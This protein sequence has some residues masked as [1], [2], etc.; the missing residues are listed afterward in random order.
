MQS[1][2]EE[3]RARILQTAYRLFAQ[4]GYDATGV[5]QICSEAGVS[6][7]A[8]YHH[9]PGKHTVFMCLL[10]DWLST[11]NI[12]MNQLTS[13]ATT[14]PQTLIR[15][16][17]ALNHIFRDARGHFPMFLEFWTQSSRDPQV[18]QATVAPYRRYQ[19]YFA[20]LLQQG[21]EEGSIRDEDVDETASVIIAMVLGVIL[22]GLLEPDSANGDRTAQKGME[23]IMQAIARRST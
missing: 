19:S 18:W 20:S 5:S 23:L 13:G 11:I 22:Q 15:M 8:F 12:E 3:T 9:F 17:A 16:T 10:E 6:K 2:S 1:R 7:G 14:V 4:Q 21:V